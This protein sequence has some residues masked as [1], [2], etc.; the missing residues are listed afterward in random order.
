MRLGGPIGSSWLSGDAREW[1]DRSGGRFARLDE[2]VYGITKLFDA[3]ERNDDRIASTGDRFGDPQKS[4]AGILRQVKR[5]MLAFNLN[6]LVEQTG[7]HNRLRWLIGWLHTSFL[8][9][10]ILC[11]V[12]ES[13]R[14][15]TC[16]S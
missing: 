2:L 5:D 8:S 3:R 15:E 10:G 6:A 11:P 4:S 9:K 14:I 1:P 12:A 13:A 7:F 16:F